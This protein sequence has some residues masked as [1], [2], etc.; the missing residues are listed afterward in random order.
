V[1]HLDCGDPFPP[2]GRS[3]HVWTSDEV[4][5]DHVRRHRA[6]IELRKIDGWTK[7]GAVLNQ[8]TGVAA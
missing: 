1:P 4:Y 5:E 2:T 7:I 8:Q 6:A 3:V